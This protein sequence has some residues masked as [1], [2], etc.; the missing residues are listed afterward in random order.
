MTTYRATRII[1]SAEGVPVPVWPSVERHELTLAEVAAL[2]ELDPDEIKWAIEAY[3][4][5]ETDKWVVE[6]DD[7]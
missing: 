5:A 2:T 3:G 6:E 7:A 1:Y 4:Q